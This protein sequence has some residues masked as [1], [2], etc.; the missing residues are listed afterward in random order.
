M[1][2]MASPLLALLVIGG[3]VVLYLSSQGTIN[4]TSSRN[5]YLF[6]FVDSISNDNI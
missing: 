1:K 5:A 6:F 3:L 4:C 2:Q